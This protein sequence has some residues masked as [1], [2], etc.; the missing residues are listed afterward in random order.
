[1]REQELL[2]LFHYNMLIWFVCFSVI[3]HCVSKETSMR[4]KPFLCV[5]TEEYRAKIWPVK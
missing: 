5:T 1:M 3:M 4:A 2:S